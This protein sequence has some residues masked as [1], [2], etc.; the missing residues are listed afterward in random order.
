[1]VF[2]NGYQVSSTTDPRE[3]VRWIGERRFDVIV[4]DQRM[5]EMTGVEVLKQAQQLSPRSVRVL[6]TGYSDTDAILDAINEV[7]VHRFLQK[8]WDNQRLKQVVDEA[9]ELARALAEGGQAASTQAPAA[10]A[11]TAAST[12]AQAPAPVPPP[13]AAPALP[14]PPPAAVATP[15]AAEPSAAAAGPLSVPPASIPELDAVLVVEPRRT[16]AE[17]IRQHCPGCEVL[18]A[19][20]IDGVF[21]ILQR[22]AL[23]TL[24]WAFDP[25][26][27]ADRAFLHLLKREY[28]F[29]LVIAVCRSADSTRL[30][31]LINHMK[32]FRYLRE[33][34]SPR[35]LMH[36]LASAAKVAGEARQNRSLLLQQ[37]PE[38][39]APTA[40]TQSALQVLEERFARM[41]NS[42]WH[43]F[44]G[45]LMA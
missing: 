11:A 30:I 26:N 24:V 8:P 9:V 38:P 1:V 28:P 21:D 29:I 16:L 43:R 44:A 3:A 45:W 33:P 6:L 2:R 15:R 31:E 10:S 20:D 40:R 39:M 13:A 12:T 34:V 41:R 37:R 5:P 17:L 19:R 7:E 23:S 36:Y 35:M 4:S 22:R 42:L 18:A 25:E 14:A 27:D 32:I